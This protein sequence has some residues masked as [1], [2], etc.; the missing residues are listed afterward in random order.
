MEL[1]KAK[2]FANLIKFSPDMMTQSEMTQSSTTNDTN[3]QGTEEN[4]SLKTAVT[5]KNKDTVRYSFMFL[6]RELVRSVLN[7]MR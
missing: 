7:P 5:K 6:P 1:S 4:I 2:Y 3:E